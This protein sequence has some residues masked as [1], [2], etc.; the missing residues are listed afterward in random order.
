MAATTVVIQSARADIPAEYRG[1][2]APT[3]LGFP[4]ALWYV[5]S[6]SMER[7]FDVQKGILAGAGVAFLLIYGIL[8]VR[9][10]AYPFDLEWMEGG[11][12]D[13]VRW[14]LAG[15]KLYV[16]PSID[17]VPFIYN[18]LYFYVCAAVAKVTGV[19][20]LPL[21][22]VSFLASVGTFGLVF[23]LVRHET[24][25][26]RL[27]V[28][29][30]GLYAATFPRSVQFMDIARTDSLYVFLALAGVAV[31]RLRPTAAG[32][33]AA[34][35]LLVLSFLTKQSGAL[36][37]GTVC[38]A[39][40]FEHRRAAIPFVAVVSVGIFGSIVALDVIHDGWYRFY[41]FDL[42]S[43]HLLVPWLW[44]GF[45]TDDVMAPLALAVA[46]SVWS[47]VQ[48]PSALYIAAFVGAVG[49]AWSGR[50]HD[51]GWLNV[52]MPMFALLAV[53]APIGLHHALE[54]TNAE[55]KAGYFLAGVFAVQF[56]LLVY[57]PRRML[58]TAADREAGVAL[59]E[60]IQA[61]PGE[62]FMPTHSFYPVLAGRRSYL[63]QMAVDDVLRGKSG[64]IGA[65]LHQEIKRALR[66]RRFS[67]VITDNDFFGED[68][69]ASYRPV[70]KAFDREGVFLPVTGVRYRPGEIFVPR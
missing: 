66:Q 63:H 60:K 25:D 16:K 38:L 17:F 37:A 24:G 35:V 34:A 50:L 47:L 29:G 31:L 27:G 58:P 19:G 8:A 22:L 13:H 18:P 33:V 28:I 51:G 20:Y 48:R 45:W 61:V 36:V 41:A 69:R 14:I 62:V 52:L 68:V 3:S 12:V 64:L 2:G 26:A 5:A 9:R 4:V 65:V 7:R 67:L 21:R 39:V 15:K 49:A 42:P 10:L 43:S 6:R 55:R 30:A 23:A 1:T 11:M 57:D 54:A 40:L 56:A 32:R 53:L 59:I 46:F 44:G 70:Q